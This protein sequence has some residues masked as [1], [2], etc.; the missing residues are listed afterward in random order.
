[1]ASD[2][3]N[4]ALVA[5]LAPQTVP[6]S[7]LAELAWLIEQRDFEELIL[8]DAAIASPQVLTAMA[9]S[10]NLQKLIFLSLD[11]VLHPLCNNVVVGRGFPALT[12]I[13]GQFMTVLSML[14]AAPFS[15]LQ[16]IN[17]KYPVPWTASPRPRLS[18]SWDSIR[19]FLEVVADHAPNL[20]SLHFN[21][22][23]NDIDPS[24]QDDGPCAFLPLSR[25]RHLRILDIDLQDAALDPP[26]SP[27]IFN[28]TDEDWLVLCKA[29]PQLTCLWY[30]CGP[31][32]SCRS[33]TPPFNPTPKATTKTVLQLLQHCKSLQTINIPIRATRS[34]VKACLADA[35]CIR[36]FS[37]TEIEAWGSHI[38]PDCVEDLAEL[39]TTVARN[40]D[41]G[42]Y[43]PVCRQ[44]A[45]GPA[46]PPHHYDEVPRSLDDVELERCRTWRRVVTLIQRFRINGGQKRLNQYAARRP[47]LAME[48]GDSY[49]AVGYEPDDKPSEETPL[50]VEFPGDTWVED[51]K[52]NWV[53]HLINRYYPKSPLLVYDYAVGGDNIKG[54]ERQIKRQQ[55]F[56]RDFAEAH[57]DASIFIFDAWDVFEQM[58]T[59][60]T[61]Y[62]FSEKAGRGFDQ[63]MYWDAIHPTTAVHRILA[64]ALADF[65]AGESVA[66]DQPERFAIPSVDDGTPQ[67]N[68]S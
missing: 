58:L 24:T 61:K 3:K 17:V 37:L 35:K 20:E 16:E 6:P 26:G 9:N 64:K 8:H 67:E 54:L 13:S 44:L 22:A 29:W 31:N 52:P 33:H 34:T 62:G 50:G 18:W 46:Q 2:L 51:K 19:V 63:E 4:L 66:E 5:E 49:S 42:L 23:A 45:I 40:P 53:G 11:D 36:H 30:I 41:F 14:H 59:D 47:G 38:E 21:L 27:N 25:C 43:A 57:P 55:L 15:G 48:V 60:P 32:Q 7:D 39:L 65:L 68:T 56:I 1:Y 12:S 10:P 28:P